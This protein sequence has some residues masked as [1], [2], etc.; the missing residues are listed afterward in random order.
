MWGEKQVQ[1]HKDSQ[2]ETMHNTLPYT[3]TMFI[4][5]IINSTILTDKK[6][7]RKSIMD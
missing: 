2:R 6:R 1:A 5:I 4:T 7:K 3:I